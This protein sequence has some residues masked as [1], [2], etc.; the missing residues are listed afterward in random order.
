[1]SRE[2]GEYGGCGY[3]HDKIAKAK[4]DADGGD[5]RGAKVMAALLAPLAD[6]A[7]AV[8]SE[9]AGDA[10][11]DMVVSKF[12]KAFPALRSALHAVEDFIEPAVDYAAEILAR[13][14]EPRC[15]VKRISDT[16]WEVSVP[17]NIDHTEAEWEVRRQALAS[18]VQRAAG[19]WCHWA[20]STSSSDSDVTRHQFISPW[21]APESNAWLSAERQRLMKEVEFLKT[22]VTSRA[23]ALPRE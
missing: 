3:F 5:T 16:S 15:T 8:A 9:E 17:K 11:E 23:A 20:G 10:G 22:Q 2:F 7:Y 21:N 4:E 19:R 1:M 18:I 12:A 6:M 14:L 13:E